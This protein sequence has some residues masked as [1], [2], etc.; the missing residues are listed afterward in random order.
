VL[1]TP[2]RDCVL[3]CFN[4]KAVTVGTESFCV[5]I[6]LESGRA[7]YGHDKWRGV[8]DSP[9]QMRMETLCTTV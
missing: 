4:T 6:I 3:L 1:T 8:E 5:G 7:K 9:Q 2:S